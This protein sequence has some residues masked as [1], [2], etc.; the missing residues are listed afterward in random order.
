MYEGREQYEIQFRRENCWG[1]GVIGTGKVEPATSRFSE[2]LSSGRILTAAAGMAVGVC[3]TL[4]LVVVADPDKVSVAATIATAVAVI[5]ALAV[6]VVPWFI[7]YDDRRTRSAVIASRITHALEV[8]LRSAAVIRDGVG[9]SAET[10]D[11]RRIMTSAQRCMP[12][13]PET[14]DETFDKLGALPYR[15]ARVVCTGVMAAIDLYVGT[16]AIANL[17]YDPAFEAVK[18]Q[19][20]A[21]NKGL[22]PP[23]LVAQATVELGVQMRQ[24]G[25]MA[26]ARAMEAQIRINAAIDILKRHGAETPREWSEFTESPVPEV[27]D[28]VRKGAWPSSTY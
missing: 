11:A 14:L 15:D 16:W 21:N 18:M 25:R 28:A 24:L 23:D 26:A 19:I 22:T 1:Y 27:A 17:D 10:A 6:G 2:K 4:S 8:A 20:V 13:A 5:V 9:H 7:A 12:R 3:I